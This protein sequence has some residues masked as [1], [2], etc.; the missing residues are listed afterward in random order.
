[1]ITIALN[2]SDSDDSEAEDSGSGDVFRF[3]SRLRD[4]NISLVRPNVAFGLSSTFLRFTGRLAAS[5]AA[6]R[7]RFSSSN[8]ANR[9][10]RSSNAF[11]VTGKVV[12]CN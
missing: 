9:W 2:A 10:S 11:R 6:R 5:N 7:R 1:M 3:P 4:R 8:K 12:C